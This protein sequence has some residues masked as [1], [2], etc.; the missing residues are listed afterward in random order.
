MA[1]TG[2]SPPMAMPAAPVT[3]CCSAMPTS[4][5][6]SG[7]RAW[8]GSRPVGPVIAAVIAT[9]RGSASASLTMASAKA[10]V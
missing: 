7:K 5:H 8:N 9:T 10:C 3:A 6:R 4:K 2:R 1:T